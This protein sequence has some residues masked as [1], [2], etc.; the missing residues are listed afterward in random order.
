[1]GSSGTA[2]RRSIAVVRSASTPA[3]ALA[4]GLAMWA[5]VSAV[6]YAEGEVDVGIVADRELVTVGDVATLT[7]TVTH[8][9]GHRVVPPRMDQTWGE[10]EV[11]SV[12]QPTTSSIGGDL[13]TTTQTIDVSLFAPGS[14]ETP[15]LP[16]TVRDEAGNVTK[17]VA[18]PVGFTV[19]SVL[20]EDDLELR[21][22]SPQAGLPFPPVWPWIVLAVVLA[23]ALAVAGW[24]L[25][26]RHL[27]RRRLDEAIAASIDPRTPYEIAVDE[28]ARID[29]LGLLDQGRF[30]EHYTLVSETLR[31]YVRGIFYVPALDLTTEELR[32]S[33]V[34]ADVAPEHG[35]RMVET[36][37]ESDLVKFARFRPEA[38][39]AG[40]LTTEVRLVVD[41]TRPI[42]PDE[43]MLAGAEAARGGAA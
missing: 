6:L 41:A 10:F 24:I 18:G 37:A 23:L 8:P 26:R 25:Y 16:V 5:I 22:I 28:L 29:A 2:T 15:E 33:M 34:G 21:D 11:R 39:E 36:L 14:F 4:L 12:S 42:V 17:H 31:A 7:L 19:V 20:S 9:V 35:R 43:A 1:M 3:L 40:K 38:S 32:A 30:K 27:A 13:E